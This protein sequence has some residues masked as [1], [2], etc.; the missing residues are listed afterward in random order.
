MRG[1][2]AVKTEQV[3]VWTGILDDK[4][5]GP[6]FFPANVNQETY[7]DMLG[8]YLMPEL[9]SMGIDPSDVWFQQDGAPPHFSCIV[10]HWLDENF[11]NWIGRGGP[12]PWP[13]RSP[14]H[15]PMD[16]FLWGYT[17]HNVYLEQPRDLVHLMTRIKESFALIT[18]QMLLRVH[19]G[20]IT[21]LTLCMN[22][23]GAHIEHVRKYKK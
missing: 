2:K 20:V 15:T 8:N 13:L 4:V 5:I 1:L 9:H 7:L 22:L 3:M 23:G 21:R 12:I 18:P 16:F 11:P 17:K 19:Y 14:D 6:Y 10:R